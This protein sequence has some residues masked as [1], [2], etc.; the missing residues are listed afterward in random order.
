M[1][2]FPQKTANVKRIIFTYPCWFLRINPYRIAV[3]GNAWEKP[4]W[5]DKLKNLWE[6][7]DIFY[8]NFYALVDNVSFDS[9]IWNFQRLGIR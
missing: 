9:I 2:T 1:K 6:I 4:S 8:S 3:T 7:F 5:E